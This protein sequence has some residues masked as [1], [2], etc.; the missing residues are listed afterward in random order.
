[1]FGIFP[2]IATQIKQKRWLLLGYKLA[3]ER[4]FLS[5]FI[6]RVTVLPN[7]IPPDRA[8]AL[9]FRFGDLFS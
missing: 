7:I 3:D 9:R 8:A 5:P 4:L 1:V 6:D 2:S